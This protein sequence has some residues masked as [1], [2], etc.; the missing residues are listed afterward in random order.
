[1]PMKK[2]KNMKRI[3]A[4]LGLT[5]LMG[6][7][8]NTNSDCPRKDKSCGRNDLTSQEKSVAEQKEVAQEA[9]PVLENITPS[10]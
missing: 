2:E 10:K 5:L 6:C 7:G 3:C 8:N 9:T 1:M 4:V